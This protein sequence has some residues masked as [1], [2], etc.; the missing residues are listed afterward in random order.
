MNGGWKSIS[1]VIT[2]TSGG[3]QPRVYG[4]R[5]SAANSDDIRSNYWEVN[6]VFN[7]FLKKKNK[8]PIGDQ[9]LRRC[10]DD[11]PVIWASN[12]YQPN[13]T[14][15]QWRSAIHDFMAHVFL[16]A[17][18]EGHLWGPP[19]KYSDQCDFLLVKGVTEFSF[20]KTFKSRMLFVS[21]SPVSLNSTLHFVLWYIRTHTSP[22]S[23]NQ[24][25]I[26]RIMFIVSYQYKLLSNTSFTKRN[27]TVATQF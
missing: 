27:T 9:W 18:E 13:Q 22:R 7:R 15:I 16:V 5:H 17:P 10:H 1:L 25:N 14:T 2:S 24:Q 8:Q 3:S 12:C 26:Y 11:L 4:W 19:G 21:S 23:T 6:S 20:E